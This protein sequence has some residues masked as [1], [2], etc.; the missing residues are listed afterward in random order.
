MVRSRVSLDWGRGIVC[1]TLILDISNIARVS[2][3][4]IVGDNL[5]AAVGKGNTVLSSSVV[6]IPLLILGKVGSRVGVSHGVLISIDSWGIF[7]GWGLV[8]SWLV[9]WSRLV[10]WGWS[11]GWGASWGSSG[12]SGGGNGSNKSL[13]TNCIFTKVTEM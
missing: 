7:I 5:G 2:I 3:G 8:G 10:S 1:L 6:A 9:S 13:K 12:N 11:I 4:N